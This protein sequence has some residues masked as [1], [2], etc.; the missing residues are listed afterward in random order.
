MRAQNTYAVAYV[1]DNFKFMYL[2]G[3]E[4]LV[5]KNIANVLYNGFIEKKLHY[6][7]QIF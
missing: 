1:P 7:V 2:L 3:T 6:N 5:K 4:F